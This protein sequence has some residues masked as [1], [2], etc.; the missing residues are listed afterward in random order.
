MGPGT[1]LR[2]FIGLQIGL[3]SWESDY[4]PWTPKAKHT[5]SDATG[6][7]LDSRGTHFSDNYEERLFPGPRKKAVKSANCADD[8]LQ[9]FVWTKTLHPTPA[10]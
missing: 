7:S 10:A 1:P 2:T 5:L 6:E 4:A 3:P 8:S 9:R